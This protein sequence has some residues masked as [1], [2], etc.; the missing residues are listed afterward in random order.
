MT[1]EEVEHLILATPDLQ[2]R[3][4]FVTAYAAPATSI[5]A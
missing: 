5:V 4:A 3:A 2:H 1:E